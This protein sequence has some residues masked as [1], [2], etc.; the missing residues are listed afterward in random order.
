MHTLSRKRV[1]FFFPNCFIQ[2]PFI[3]E[4]YRWQSLILW[5]LIQNK[6]RWRFQSKLHCHGEERGNGVCAQRWPAG[7]KKTKQKTKRLLWIKVK[8]LF[9]CEERLLFFPCRCSSGRLQMEGLRR[10]HRP[11][12]G[13]GVRLPSPLQSKPPPPLFFFFFLQ[14]SSCFRPFAWRLSVAPRRYI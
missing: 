5:I 14:P 1:L 8:V 12:G 6:R 13:L 2:M 4:R 9:H 10:P 7:W 11:H 3:S